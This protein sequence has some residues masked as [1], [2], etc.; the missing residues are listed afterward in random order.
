MRK[1]V[2]AGYQEKQK[3]NVAK[4]C[5]LPKLDDVYNIRNSSHQSTILRYGVYR[6]VVCLV[7][8]GNFA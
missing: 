1:I 7:H 5:N 8:R 2:L 3:Y 4:L 6:N